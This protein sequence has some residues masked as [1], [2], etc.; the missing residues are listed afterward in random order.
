M[1]WVMV[2]SSVHVHITLHA[3]VH[4]PAPL[5]Q[6]YVLGP[7]SSRDVS[8]PDLV[9]SELRILQ[10][11]KDHTYSCTVAQEEYERAQSLITCECC[12]DTVRF[13][14]MCA[15]AGG[16][17]LLCKTCVQRSF[18][19]HLV[20]LETRVSAL[21]HAL[22]NAHNTRTTTTPPHS[23][24][25]PPELN[26]GGLPCFACASGDAC[27]SHIPY[28]GLRQGLRDEQVQAYDKLVTKREL[29]WCGY[30]VLECPFCGAL[31]WVH[32]SRTSLQARARDLHGQLVRWPYLVYI[33]DLFL[34]RFLLY[35]FLGTLVAPSLL[36]A[37]VP[38]LIIVALRRT[39]PRLTGSQFVRCGNLQCQVHWCRLCEGEAH[40][41]ESCAE[42]SG[43]EPTAEGLRKFVERQMAKALVRTCPN[44]GCQFHK[45]DGCNKMTCKCGLKM[46]Y[47]CRK[48]IQDYTHFCQHFRPLG[49]GQCSQ[50]D[51]CDL[52]QCPDDDRTIK[53][54]GRQAV[55][56]FFRKFPDQRGKIPRP[57]KVGPY[58]L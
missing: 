3:A 16:A 23:Q 40:L 49:G 30:R 45:L 55:E 28:S 4:P 36:S 14:E 44:C 51:K 38:F 1:Q 21:L 27:D 52:Y 20:Q 57:K 12:F 42:E 48:E 32:T 39:A 10:E 13:D 25:P 54:T 11:R 41:G 37:V 47:V 35:F 7:R 9:A 56:A 43:V 17:H 34:V 5:P 31:D 29:V 24:P 33:Q 53:Q 8:R 19:D 50:C 26:H 58:Q 22:D 2:F 46:C 15:C 18:D 6:D